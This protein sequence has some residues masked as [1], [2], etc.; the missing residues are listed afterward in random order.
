MNYEDR[1][2]L[3]CGRYGPP[4]RTLYHALHRQVSSI[5]RPYPPLP[6]HLILGILVRAT[7]QQQADGL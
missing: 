4:P 6:T 7:A 1:L 2:R 3:L 5:H